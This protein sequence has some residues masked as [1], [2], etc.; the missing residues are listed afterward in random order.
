MIERHL[1]DL[2]GKDFNLFLEMCN[3]GGF[4]FIKYGLDCPQD[5]WSVNPVVEFLK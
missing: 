5:I 3:C 4:N 2:F 1:Q